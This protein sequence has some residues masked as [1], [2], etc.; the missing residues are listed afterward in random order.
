MKEY[1]HYSQRI[2]ITEAGE[3]AFNLDLFEH[4]YEGNI[5]ITKRLTNKL[6][7]KLLEN[8]ERIILHLTCTGHGGTILEPLVPTAEKTHEQLKKLLEGGFPVKQVVLRIDPILP[9]VEGRHIAYNVA[10][11]FS[12]C[13]IKRLRFSVLDMYKHVK[14]RFEKAN[15]SIPYTSFHA[16]N[17]A[18]Q[19]VLRGLNAIA[20]K[21]G[22]T[23]E[24]CAEPGIESCPCL[25]QK[26]IVLLGLSE[27]IKLYS[28]AQQRK[29]CKCPVNKSEL[30]K[31]GKPHRC[32]NACLYCFWKD[33]G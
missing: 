6:I 23:I 13:G 2:G 33:E 29:N 15:Y 32:E 25:S 26:D 28:S 20:D 19:T 22:Y 7:D 14:E 18:R 5:I 21:Y 12:D 8:K 17:T 1:V 10:K 31:K 16:S 4:L 30:I 27:K 9:T 11:L 24:A 3:P